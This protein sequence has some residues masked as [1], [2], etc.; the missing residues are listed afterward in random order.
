MLTRA[1][2]DRAMVRTGLDAES[3]SSVATDDLRGLIGAIK[4]KARFVRSIQARTGLDEEEGATAHEQ[5]TLVCLD[6]VIRRLC[7]VCRMAPHD[8]LALTVEAYKPW[9]Q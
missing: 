9:I 2:I 8:A 7:G 6:D 1:D 4:T 3:R 5:A